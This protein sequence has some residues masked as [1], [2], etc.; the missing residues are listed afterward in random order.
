MNFHYE[1]CAHYSLGY[2]AYA[3]KFRLY[4]VIRCMCVTAHPRRR[5]YTSVSVSE[6]VNYND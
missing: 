4:G 6:T 1:S 2:C 5:C 3:V